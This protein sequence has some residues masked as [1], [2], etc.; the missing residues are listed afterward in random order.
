MYTI[1]IAEVS[2]P[3]ARHF[4]YCV[5][6]IPDYDLNPNVGR[7]QACIALKAYQATHR[8]FVTFASAQA[9]STVLYELLSNQGVTVR[10]PPVHINLD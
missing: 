2:A 8:P 4:V 5:L 10:S 9:E 1:V 6:V 7:I 3:A